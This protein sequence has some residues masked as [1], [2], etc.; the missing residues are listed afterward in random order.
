MKYAGRWD[1]EGNTE[2]IIAAGVYYV[3]FDDELE[4]GALKYRPKRAQQPQE[5]G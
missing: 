5:S 4:G 2:N 3:Y 1:T